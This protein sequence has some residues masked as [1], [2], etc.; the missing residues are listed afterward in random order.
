MIK[1]HY[2]YLH[3]TAQHLY[4]EHTILKSR[5]TVYLQLDLFWE[6]DKRLLD[7][8]LKQKKIMLTVNIYVNLNTWFNF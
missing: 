1:T 3:N 8:T 4:Y 6:G 2:D 5:W 7:K